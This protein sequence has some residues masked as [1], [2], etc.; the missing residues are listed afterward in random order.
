MERSDDANLAA[1]LANHLW[2]G[3]TFRFVA[4]QEKKIEALSPADVSKAF[5][6]V[7]DP[8]KLVIAEAGDFQKK[9]G[10]EKP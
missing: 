10:K 7:L 2:L 3:R 1:E 8:K 9:D 5:G 6:R 4:E